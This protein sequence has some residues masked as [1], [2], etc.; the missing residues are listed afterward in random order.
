MRLIALTFHGLGDPP[1][2]VSAEEKAHWFAFDRFD[3]LVDRIWTQHDPARYAFTFDDGNASDLAAARLLAARGAAA[4]FFVLVGRIGQPGYLGRDDL[5]TLRSA[6]MVIGL[7]GRA[8]LDWSQLDQP[9]F[10]DETITARRELSAMLGEPVD[11][12]AIPFG[13][14]NSRVMRALKAQGFA[15]IHTSDRGFLRSTNARIWNRNT[16][17]AD[18]SDAALEA[19]LRGSASPAQRARRLVS[20]VM[21]R[22]VK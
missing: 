4:R 3:A 10:T 1:A 22:H 12:V 2:H 14:Y 18:M 19:I 7:H 21:R 6:G 8:H 15:H 13:I 9:A 17:R 16:L 20:N 5:L 11:E